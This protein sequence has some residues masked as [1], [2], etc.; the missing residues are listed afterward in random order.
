MDLGDVLYCLGGGQNEPKLTVE[1]TN[2]GDEHEA[3]LYDVIHDA[4]TVRYPEGDARQHG[5]AAAK[6]N[7]VRGALDALVAVLAG[8][9]LSYDVPVMWKS[10]TERLRIPPTLVSGNPTITPLD[11]V[12]NARRA[13][14]W[15]APPA[16]SEEPLPPA[17]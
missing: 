14:E 11:Q 8:S 12:S 5:E 16:P 10:T 6:G 9:F 2:N 13:A 17:A 15:L 3:V 7:G 1:P 4:C